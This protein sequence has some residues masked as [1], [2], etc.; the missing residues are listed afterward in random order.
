MES[1]GKSTRVDGAAVDVDT[2]PV[3]WGGPGTDAQHSF[4]QA[5]HQGTEVASAD[6]IGVITPD[7]PYPDNHRALLANLLAQSEAFALG[8]ASDDPHRSYPGNRPNTLILMDAL[9]PHSLGMLLAMYEHSVYLQAV[10]WD[11]NPFDQFGVEL[12]KEVATR[13]WP[14]LAGEGAVGAPITRRALAEVRRSR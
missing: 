11:I 9:T 2:V 10:L 5:L 8:R 12:G 3:W 14:A 7:T 6:L 1:L 4:F 13:R